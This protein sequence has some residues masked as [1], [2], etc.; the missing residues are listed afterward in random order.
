MTKSPDLASLESCLRFF[1]LFS[2]VLI[3]QQNSD[4]VAERLKLMSKSKRSYRALLP[5][6]TRMVWR[7]RHPNQFFYD[8]PK[9]APRI[10]LRKCLQGDHEITT[11]KISRAW[12][13][14][15]LWTVIATSMATLTCA[16]Q[17][18]F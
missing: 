3:L 16:P 11:Y 17:I 7:W 18:S 8:C 14:R 10:I 12:T 1:A 6:F 5:F 2:V 4:K 13:S 15:P 9:T